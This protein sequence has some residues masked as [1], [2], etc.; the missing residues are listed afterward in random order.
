MTDDHLD[1][2]RPLSPVERWYWIA[3][4]VS[5]LNVIARAQVRGHLSLPVLRRA[6]DRIQRRHPLLNVAISTGPGG[7][8]PAFVPGGG[9]I[10]L[11]QVNRD[12]QGGEERW[13]RQVNEHELDERIDWR[14]GPLC[15]AV[16]LSGSDAAGPVHDLLLT[17]P[18]CVA[19]GTTVMALL[20]EWLLTAAEQEPDDG[21]AGPRPA[22]IVGPAL[23][24]E[25]LFPPRYRGRLGSLRLLRHPLRD[26]ARARRYRPARFT[27]SSFVPYP[28]RRTRLLHR[29]LTAGQVAALVAACRRER[30]T[31][32]GALAAAMVTAVA[33]DATPTPGHITIGSPLDMRADLVPPVPENAVGAY[34]ATVPTLVAYR[35]GGSFWPMARAISEDLAHRRRTGGH[36]AM[37]NL[38][39]L[40]GPA[41]L[42]SSGRFIDLV[43]HRGPVNFCLSNI[44]RYDFPARIG[45]WQVS[46]AQFVAGLSVC[47]YFVATVNTSHDQLCWNF[48]YV[49]QA[50]PDDRARHLADRCVAVV[51]DAIAAATTV[52]ATQRA[53]S[54]EERQWSDR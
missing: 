1:A 23:P 35:P 12:D 31:V 40:S 27:P 3:D 10:P 20:K 42:R 38:V 24:A 36:L 53:S 26:W 52:S 29:R 48:L 13:V 21:V 5:P 25:A 28:Q 11:R 18:H 7:A 15:R 47:G 45:P 17:M 43:E 46:G 39:G 6:L 44:G 9:P 14:Q 2:S 37:I 4:Q 8:N 34:V 51:S 49:R 16:V 19:D 22:G 33:R 54:T 41:S 50:V 32:H 30:T